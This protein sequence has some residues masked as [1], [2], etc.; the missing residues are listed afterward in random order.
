MADFHDTGALWRI[1]LAINLLDPL[2][3]RPTFFP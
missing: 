1:P 2:K 3:G